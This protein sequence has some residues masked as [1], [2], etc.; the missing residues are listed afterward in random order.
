MAQLLNDPAAARSCFEQSLLHAREASFLGGVAF[1][2]RNIGL[3][4]AQQGD[5]AQAFAL[6]Q[7]SLDLYRQLDIQGGIGILLQTLGDVWA[8]QDA[9]RAEAYYRESLPIFRA[10]GYEQLTAMTLGDLAELALRRRSALEAR[11]YAEECLVLGRVIDSPELIVDAL[12]VLGSG[13]RLEGE[14]ERAGVYYRES[15]QRAYAWGDARWTTKALDRVVELVLEKAGT[16]SALRR[17][18]LLAGAAEALRERLAIPR[19]AKDQTEHE[20]SVAAAYERADGAAFEAAWA[21]GEALSLDQVVAAALALLESRTPQ[22]Q[23]EHG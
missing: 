18:A 8:D 11:E 20:R 14:R 21:E 4:A 2:L 1:A 12:L 16:Y 10:I 6:Y 3:M 19:A 23:Q 5:Q 22:C 15:L 7:E 17:A 13:A 9:A